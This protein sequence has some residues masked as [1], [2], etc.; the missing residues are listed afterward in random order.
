MALWIK[1]IK[2]KYNQHNPI[3]TLQWKLEDN[4]PNLPQGQTIPHLQSARNFH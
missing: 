2:Y 4:H 1:L 3:I